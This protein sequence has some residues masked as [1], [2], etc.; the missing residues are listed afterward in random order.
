MPQNLS[1]STSDAKQ[2]DINNRLLITSINNFN[3]FKLKLKQAYLNENFRYTELSKD[4]D[5]RYIA[6]SL[7]SDLNLQYNTNNKLFTLGS[8]F[9]F[10]FNRK[11]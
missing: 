5:S 7:I 11:Q 10:K 1:T 3:A 4:I 6:E 2:Y 8:S 9:K